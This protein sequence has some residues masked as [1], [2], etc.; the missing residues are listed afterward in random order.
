MSNEEAHSLLLERI[1][2]LENRL[3]VRLDT[4]E[5]KIDKLWFKVAAISAT[6]GIIATKLGITLGGA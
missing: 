1:R 3:D 4:V 5:R 2:S 6:V